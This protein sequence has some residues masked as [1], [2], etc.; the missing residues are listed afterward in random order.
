MTISHGETQDAHDAVHAGQRLDRDVGDAEEDA[1]RGAEHDAVV[2]VRR[3]EVLARDEQHRRRRACRPRRRSSRAARSASARPAPAAASRRAA[4]GR[5]A[6]RPTPH[7]WR[8]P[9]SKPKTRSASTASITTPVESTA[10]TTDSGANAIA[11]TCRTQAPTATAMP[12]ANHF[13]A[14]SDLTLSHGRRMSTF[15]GVTGAAVLVQEAELRHEGAAEREQ[16]S[17]VER[18]RRSQIRRVER[19]ADIPVC[20]RHPLACDTPGWC[21]VKPSARDTAGRIPPL[22]EPN[23][24]RLRNLRGNWPSKLKTCL[25]RDIRD[26]RHASPPDRRRRCGLALRL[27]PGCPSPGPHDA[28][29]RYT[30][31]A[32]E[33]RR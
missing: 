11:A 29:R 12:I 22:S 13:C 5:A 4:R 24:R 16:D 18:H 8:P 10:W 25:P 27:R 28:G 17:E 32:L 20:M 7:H 23:D 1:G 30:P 15:G 6:V 14:N 21:L 19:R 26:I 33:S 3:A 9:T 31:P 2:V